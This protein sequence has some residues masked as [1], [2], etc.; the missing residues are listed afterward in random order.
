MIVFRPVSFCYV[1][2]YICEI[3][4]A[5]AALRLA[6]L[7]FWILIFISLELHLRLLLSGMILL[8]CVKHLI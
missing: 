6:L 1:L 8:C 4:T 5:V 3:T 7:F 2:C